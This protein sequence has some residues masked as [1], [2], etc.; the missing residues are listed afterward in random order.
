MVIFLPTSLL[1]NMYMRSVETIRVLSFNCLYVHVMKAH[2]VVNID[3]LILKLSAK[4]R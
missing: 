4:W 3:V 1:D 2:G